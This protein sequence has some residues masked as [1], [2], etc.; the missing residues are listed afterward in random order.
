MEREGKEGREGGVGRGGKEG[1]EGE[2]KFQHV[3]KPGQSR[4]ATQASQDPPLSAPSSQPWPESSSTSLFQSFQSAVV[5]HLSPLL[6]PLV[7][8][9]H[10]SIPLRMCVCVCVCVCVFV[11]CVIARM[12]TNCVD[13]C[14]HVQSNARSIE[15]WGVER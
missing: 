12:Y 1:R 11:M 2:C 9:H 6:P 3:M 15:E 14:A 7:A 4:F 5:R 13:V 8:L 10:H